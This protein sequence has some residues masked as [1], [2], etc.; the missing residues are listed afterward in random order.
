VT[1]AR[2]FPGSCAPSGKAAP[3]RSRRTG[4][5]GGD[6]RCTTASGHSDRGRQHLATRQVAPLPGPTGRRVDRP[7]HRHPSGRPWSP[8]TAGGLLGALCSRV[9]PLGPDAVVLLRDAGQ[10]GDVS[11]DF[12]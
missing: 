9:D 6:D 1:S 5:K 7:R 10:P 2:S 3:L 8:L 12:P 4:R 11:T